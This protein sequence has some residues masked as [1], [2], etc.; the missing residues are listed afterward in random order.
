F[1]Y[2]VQFDNASSQSINISAMTVPTSTVSFG[3]WFNTSC[4]NCGL[5]SVMTRQNFTRVYDRQLYL[6]S[7]NV[8]ADVFNGVRET[9]CSSI[10][11]Y[12]DGQWHHAAQV[13]SGGAQLLYVDGA[14][15]ASG[16]KGI[17]S[18]AATGDVSL[19]WAPAAAQPYLSGS[20]D[21][22]QMFAQT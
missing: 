22:V 11:N 16:S 7:G 18:Y 9:I 12:A 4:A 2:A 21:Q 6:S 8:C 17:S 15:A 5:A 13:L 3:V 20:L 14:L 1:G 10:A 19:G